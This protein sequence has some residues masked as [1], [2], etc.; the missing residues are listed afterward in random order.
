MKAVSAFV[1]AIVNSAD[2]AAVHLQGIT[3]YELARSKKPLPG[4]VLVTT[5]MVNT[6]ASLR[7]KL[8]VRGIDWGGKLVSKILVPFTKKRTEMLPLATF[9]VESSW[10]IVA[11]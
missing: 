10:P 6:C 3:K 7:L 1:A 8:V 2:L 11:W 9:I 4:G 5:W